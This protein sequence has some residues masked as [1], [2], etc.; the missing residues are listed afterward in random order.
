MIVSMS[1]TI[2]LQSPPLTIGGTVLK[3][4]DDLDILEVTFDYKMIFEKHLRSVYRA[5]SQRLDISGKSWRV[6]QDRLLLGRCFRGFVP[7]VLGYCSSVCCLA[8]DTHLKLLDRDITFDIAHRRYVAVLC[9]L[10]K[11]RCNPTHPLFGVLP[12]PYVPVR[13]TRCAFFAYRYTYAPPRCRSS[14]YRTT[15]VLPLMSLWD[16]LADLVFKGLR[17]AGFKSRANAFYLS[18]LLAPFL[19]STVFRFC[20]FFQ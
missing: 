4:S 16:D 18:K 6:L 5:A 13:V 3:E 19:S 14:L 2:H 7:T 15:F 20:T 17:L 10:Y 8:T 9:L 11:I 1:W 12:V